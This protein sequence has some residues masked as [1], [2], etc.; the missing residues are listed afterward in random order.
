MGRSD[1]RYRQKLQLYFPGGTCR[2]VENPRQ[3]LW[4]PGFRLSLTLICQPSDLGP[5]PSPPWILVSS[6]V[7]RVLSMRSALIPPRAAV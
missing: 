6:S 2:Q 4:R 1:M 3:G 7:R 5:V